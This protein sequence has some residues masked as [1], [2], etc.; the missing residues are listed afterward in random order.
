MKDKEAQRI[1]W[2]KDGHVML[3]NMVENLR[4]DVSKLKETD[5]E[6][7]EGLRIA[8]CPKC[9]HKVLAL[10]TKASPLCSLISFRAS[11]YSQPYTCLNC[12]CEFT[13]TQ[14][15]VSKEIEDGKQ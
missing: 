11:V 7:R 6:V 1:E 8:Y 15:E 5:T 3:K 13:V 9:K 4:C 14:E 10:L 12:G 2:L